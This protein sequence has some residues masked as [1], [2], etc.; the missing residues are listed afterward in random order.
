MNIITYSIKFSFEHSSDTID[1]ACVQVTHECQDCCSITGKS[2]LP[3]RFIPIGRDL[4]Q[5]SIRSDACGDCDFGLG[6][7]LGAKLLDDILRI[8]LMGSTIFGNV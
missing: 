6:M 4:C 2:E 5:L 3:I 7:D 1:L 8:L